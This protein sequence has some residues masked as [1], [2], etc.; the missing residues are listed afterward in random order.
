MLKKFTCIGLALSVFSSPAFSQTEGGLLDGNTY[1]SI[2]ENE[3]MSM[4][5]A[6][7]T[8]TIGLMEGLKFGVAN[9]IMLAESRNLDTASLNRQT[10]IILR[11]C[12]PY[13]VTYDQYI[14]IGTMYLRN[15]PQFTHE[16]V[17]GHLLDAW[18][19]AFPCT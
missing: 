13:E 18:S 9:V 7:T 12:A 3:D 8:Y 1:L 5:M 4:Q 14:R 15:N 11:I 17:R 16:S 19:S 10:E 6:C 2:C